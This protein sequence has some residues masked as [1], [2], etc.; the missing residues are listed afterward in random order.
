MSTGQF[1]VV[2]TTSLAAWVIRLGTRSQVNHAYIY[3]SDNYIVEAQPH[4]AVM[5]HASK[6]AGSPTSSFNLTPEEQARVRA[7]A[8][9]LVGTSYNFLDIAVLAL[10]SLGVRW[11][12]LQKR[13]QSSA[14]LICSQLVDRAYRNA[15][16]HLYDDGRPD[17]EVTPGDLLL[18]LAERSTATATPEPETGR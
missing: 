16:I 2:R 10:L 15:G 12:W 11:A 14:A 1:G 8:L 18:L 5:R 13:A 6:Y 4:G 17:G 7:A 3:V 9:A